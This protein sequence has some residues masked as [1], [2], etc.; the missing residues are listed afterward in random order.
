MT[1][2]WWVVL[3]TLAGPVI[4]VQ[5]Q[6]WIERAS[7]RSRRRQWIFQTLMANRATRL[8]DDFVRALN[9]IDLEFL[10]GWFS[11]A[12]DQA[13]ISAW[14]ALLDELSHGPAAGADQAVYLAWNVRCDDK[15]IELLAK[16]STALG[17]S[18]TSEQLRRGI[19]HPQ[20]FS[21]REQAQLVIL[22]GLRK[23]FMGQ[24]SIPMD[25]TN[26]PGNADIAKAQLD[27]ALKAAGAYD[28]QSGAL[29][30]K[31]TK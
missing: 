22:D 6:K 15:V 18:F 12:K 8:H 19:Y 23:V 16:M 28:E 10:P 24:K 31:Q 14:H 26:F 11:K 9:L 29:K 2:E 7:E 20:A 25:V 5:T 27:L 1:V 17:Y 13:V 21:E 4:A 30:I 3:A